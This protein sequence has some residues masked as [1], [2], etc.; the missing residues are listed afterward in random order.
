MISLLSPTLSLIFW[1]LIN[2][3]TRLY[4]IRKNVLLLDQKSHFFRK[5]IPL[6]ASGR[7]VGMHM[8]I[9]FN[10]ADCGVTALVDRNVTLNY[11]STLEGAVLTLTCENDITTDEQV[12]HVTCH[13]NGSWIPDPAQFTCSSFTTVPTGAITYPRIERNNNFPLSVHSLTK[14]F[15]LKC[16]NLIHTDWNQS[17]EF[18]GY[19]FINNYYYVCHKLNSDLF[20]WICL[21]LGWS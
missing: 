15:F 2:F 9:I 11:S 6:F 10:T 7:L 13:S 12:I 4:Q 14:Y 18:D 21:W 5:F 19:S 8:V 17:C 20:Y 1:A 3:V 16:R